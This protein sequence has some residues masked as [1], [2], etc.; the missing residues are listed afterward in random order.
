MIRISGA[1]TDEKAR[2]EAKLS[3]PAHRQGTRF[4]LGEILPDP[5]DG[6][7]RGHATRKPR[8]KAGRCSA[9]PSGLRKHLMGRPQNKPALQARIG[10]RMPER[11]LARTIRLAMG[12]K[13]LYV[14]AQS[15][16]RTCGADLTFATLLTAIL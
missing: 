7:P 15:R 1:Y 2:I 9:L 3:Q 8:D 11:H 10:L 12:L 16:K 4:N 6:P 5:N 13:A 14:A